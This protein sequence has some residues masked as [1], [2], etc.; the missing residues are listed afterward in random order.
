MSPTNSQAKRDAQKKADAGL[1][2]LLQ[3]AEALDVEAKYF[4]HCPLLMSKSS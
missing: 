3:T 4:A 1:D 2:E